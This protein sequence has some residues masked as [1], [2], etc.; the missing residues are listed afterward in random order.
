MTTTDPRVAAALAEWNA[1]YTA[2]DHGRMADA[3]EAL[4]DLHSR[5]S[6]VEV[7]IM[8]DSDSGLDVE[9]FVDGAPFE[10]DVS[11]V[12]NGGVDL[13]DDDQLE[14]WLAD[15]REDAKTASPAAAARILELAGSEAESRGHDEGQGDED[16]YPEVCKYCGESI[17]SDGVDSS[18]SFRCDDGD[19]TSP[20]HVAEDQQHVHYVLEFNNG[21]PVGPGYVSVTSYNETRDQLHADLADARAEGMTVTRLYAERVTGP[22]DE[23][24]CGSSEPSSA[25]A[26]GH[27]V[28]YY[29][30]RPARYD[31]PWQQAEYERGV[32]FGKARWNAAYV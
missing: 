5:T 17:D 32:A 18:G 28:G 21:K 8:R 22:S 11:V 16:D 20:F 15:R 9:T 25:F 12:D 26:E 1:A 23:C 2:Y 27:S 31:N 30:T 10:A 7:V 19:E 29:A 6:R 24:D 3:G 14:E 13:S 4:S